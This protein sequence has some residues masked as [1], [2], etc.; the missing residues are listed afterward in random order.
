MKWR[1][2]IKL[3]TCLHGFLTGL[4]GNS[5]M[6]YNSNRPKERVNGHEQSTQ[7]TSY[8]CTTSGS[9][10][11]SPHAGQF[12]SWAIS[13]YDFYLLYSLI[14]LEK[15]KKKCLSSL[16]ATSSVSHHVFQFC[17]FFFFCP[18]NIISCLSVMTSEDLMSFFL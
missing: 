13:S 7:C 5:S 1:L 6:K 14:K 2:K 4:V 15:R 8:S 18:S 3:S 11:F 16:P 17:L 10:I 12:L 9:A